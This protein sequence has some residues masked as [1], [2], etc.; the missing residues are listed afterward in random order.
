MG[1]KL[2]LVVDQ[3][4]SF[5]TTLNLTDDDGGV[6]NLTGYTAAGQL[7][8]HYT[9]SNSVSFTI[10]LGGANGTVTLAMSSNTTANIS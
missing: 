5:S 9:S 6:I 3:G 7:R 1:T 4:S 2:N 10:T 8:K